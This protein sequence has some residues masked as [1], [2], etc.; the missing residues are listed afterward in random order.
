MIKLVTKTQLAHF[1]KCPKLIADCKTCSKTWQKVSYCAAHDKFYPIGE[2]DNCNRCNK[3]LPQ[4]EMTEQF[5]P[6][7]Y[8]EPSSFDGYIC[9]ECLKQEETYF[10]EQEQKYAKK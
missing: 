3:L 7:T 2:L 5:T 4:K 1:N 9:A 8:H 6:Q 10:S